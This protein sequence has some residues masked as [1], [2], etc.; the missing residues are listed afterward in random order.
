MKR[1]PNS[2]LLSLFVLAGLFLVALLFLAGRAIAQ[3]EPWRELAYAHDGNILW[4]SDAFLTGQVQVVTNDS[5]KDHQP[6]ISPDGQTIVFVRTFDYS[7]PTDAR[8]N[9][10]LMRINYDGTGLQPLTNNDLIESWPTWSPDG[11]RLAFAAGDVYVMPVSDAGGGAPVR[12]TNGGLN[13]ENLAWSP[14]G[15]R[16]AFNGWPSSEDGQPGEDDMELYVLTVANNQLTRLTNNDAYDGDP[17]W[18]PDGARLAYENGDRYELARQIHLIAAAGGPVTPLTDGDGNNTDPAWSPDGAL[19]AYAQSGFA[20]AE[21]KVVEPDG[22]ARFTSVGARQRP[23]RPL[24]YSE[25]TVLDLVW[26]TDGQLIY[27]ESLE[28]CGS[29]SCFNDVYI[30]RVDLDSAQSTILFHATDGSLSWWWP[31]TWSAVGERLAYIDTAFHL[32]ALDISTASPGPA[33]Q[34]TF[35]ESINSDPAWS[36][37]GYQLAFTGRGPSGYSIQVSDVNGRNRR[38]LTPQPGNDWNPSWSVNDR[39]AFTSNRDGNWELYLMN[40][41]GSGQTRL[42]NTPA[43]AENDAAWSPD[44]MRLA[45][46]RQQNGNW[47]IYLMNANGSGVTRLTTHAGAD[48]NPAWS[49]DGARIAFDS[50]RDGNK[51]IYILTVAGA[52]GNE[53]NL[54]RR[55]GDQSEPSWSPDGATLAFTRLDGVATMALADPMEVLGFATTSP[56]PQPA[57]RPILPELTPRVWTPVVR[58][59]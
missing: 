32:Y 12:L 46:A 22:T 52:P 5:K 24:P 50:D 48:R 38:V 15:T 14:D 40:T 34:L 25:W 29:F 37:G 55:A 58:R 19:I 44:G 51:E 39:I 10:E 7:Y 31:T 56:H 3:Q 47:D 49:P 43:I 16:L 28:G 36:P 26:T 30:R 9:S 35:V 54:T 13:P 4:H 11:T 23:A 45:Y 53:T 41:D 27:G 8:R 59:Q 33:R 21:I 42:T 17:A 1:K 6:V 20:A 57:W 18:S 2:R